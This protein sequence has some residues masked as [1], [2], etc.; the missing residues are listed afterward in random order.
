MESIW[1][2]FNNQWHA[3]TALVCTTK[4]FFNIQSSMEMNTDELNTHALLSNNHPQSD[5]GDFHLSGLVIASLESSDVRKLP[6][7]VRAILDSRQS[8]TMLDMSTWPL[9]L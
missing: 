5:Q 1:H 8:Y 4:N 6:Y 2:T 7:K 3:A 9:K